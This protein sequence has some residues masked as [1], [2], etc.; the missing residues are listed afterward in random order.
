MQG[1]NIPFPDKEMIFGLK[2]LC[3]KYTPN[4]MGFFDDTVKSVLK[5][6]SIIRIDIEDASGKRRKC[7]KEGRKMKWDRME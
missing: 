2:L 7:D 5:I 3:K 4:N 6:T 1:I